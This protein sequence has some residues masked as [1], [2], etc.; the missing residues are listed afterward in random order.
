MNLWRKEKMTTDADVVIRAIEQQLNL[1]IG[2]VK[3]GGDLVKDYGADSLDMVEIVMTLEE[4]LDIEVPD[5][6]ITDLKLH[7]VDNLIKFIESQ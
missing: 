5:D 7:D 2:T 6:A 3:S 4:Q 1:K